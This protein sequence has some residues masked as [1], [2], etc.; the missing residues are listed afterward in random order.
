MHDPERIR[1]AVLDDFLPEMVDIMGSVIPEFRDFTK[2]GKTDIPFTCKPT[3][4][5][6]KCYLP[7]S[8]AK[9]SVPQLDMS[10]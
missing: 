3:E 8:P 7:S 5:N 2:T 1:G 10:T 9:K 6:V 4:K